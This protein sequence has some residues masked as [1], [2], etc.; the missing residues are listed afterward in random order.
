MAAPTAMQEEVQARID[1]DRDALVDLVSELVRIPSLPGDE[2]SVAQHLNRRVREWGFETELL[3]MRDRG[4]SAP[5]R[6]GVVAQVR[7]TGD[8]YTLMFNGHLDTEPVSPAYAASGEDPFSGRVEDGKVFGIGTMNMKAA[9]ACFFFAIRALL[10]SG[11]RPRG[12]VIIAAVPAELNGGAGTRY[13]MESGIRA[14]MAI[15]GEASELG[16]ITAS[17]GIVNVR[18]T[19]RGTPTHMAFP[20][21]GRS[22]VEDLQ[23]I[24]SSLPS[25]EIRFDRGKFGTALEPKVNVGFIKGGY[26]FRAG[27]FM[28]SCELVL[29]IRGPKGVAPDTLREDLGQFLDGLRQ[30]RPG[31][32]ISCSVLNPIPRFMPPLHVSPEEFIVRAVHD[33]HEAVTGRAPKYSMTYA[34]VDAGTLQHLWGIP[35]VVYG[36]AGATGSFTPPEFVE[37]AELLTAS[38]TYALAAL[39]VTSRRRGELDGQIGVPI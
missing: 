10:A 7:G 8:G 25:L 34:G 30:V 33:A 22:V 29:N 9:V 15:N 12:D 39:N 5:G 32:D 21:K 20:D 4:V 27:L 24:L 23:F 35:G 16:I 31:L 36:P 6:P 37:I 14:D 19:L 28:D 26:E 11:F 1:N 17:A 3:E 2:V 38:K 18:L 13:L